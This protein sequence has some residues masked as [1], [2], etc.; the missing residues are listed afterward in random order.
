M[1]SILVYIE[2]DGESPGRASLEALGGARRVAT[3]PGAARHAFVALAGQQGMMCRSVPGL[4][5]CL[6][7]DHVQR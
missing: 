4:I 2:G 7:Q 5:A 6:V 3:Q 1:A